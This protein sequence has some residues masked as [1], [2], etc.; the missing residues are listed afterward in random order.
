MWGWGS[1]LI[2][3][4]S[5]GGLS[6]ISALSRSPA[7]QKSAVVMIHFTGT[8]INVNDLEGVKALN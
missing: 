5:P 2:S 8:G 3:P 7:P 1:A 6:Q 4:N